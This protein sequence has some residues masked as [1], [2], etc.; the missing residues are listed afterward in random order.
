MLATALGTVLLPVLS[1]FAAQ[2]KHAE[3]RAAITTPAHAAVRDDARGGGPVRAGRARRADALRARLVRPAEHVADGPRAVVLR[4]GADGVLPRQG[5]RARVLRPAGHAHAGQI[6]LCAVS[7][8]F[9]LNVAS[10][11]LLPEYWKHA[12]LAFSTVISE[13]FN[14]LLLRGS[15]AAARAVRVARHPGGA[16]RALGAAACMAAVAWF[17]EREITTWL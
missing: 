11:L 3:M 9:T 10:A 13:G 14:G 8:N 17:A 5:L 6:G 12:G 2:K 15:C 4:A 1:D 7:L 16:G